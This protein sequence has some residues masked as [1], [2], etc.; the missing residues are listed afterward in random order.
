MPSSFPV[1]Y[2][3]VSLSYFANFSSVNFSIRFLISKFYIFHIYLFCFF[4]MIF[5]AYFCL[6]YNLLF[7]YVYV[8]VYLKFL[9]H[10]YEVFFG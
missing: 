4:L 7:P 2:W 5:N 10:L 1:A 8:N 6:K 3:S 9:A